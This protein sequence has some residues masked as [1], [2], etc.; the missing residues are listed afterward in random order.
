[1]RDLVLSHGPVI[2]VAGCGRLARC[3]AES[4]SKQ[5]DPNHCRRQGNHHDLLPPT[6]IFNGLGCRLKLRSYCHHFG[7]LFKARPGAITAPCV[8]VCFGYALTSI[9]LI[10]QMNLDSAMGPL[11]ASG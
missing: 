7:A 8:V 4:K 9:L 11:N 2:A 6:G 3:G 10:C 5:G 1:M